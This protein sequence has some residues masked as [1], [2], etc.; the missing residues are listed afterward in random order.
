MQLLLNPEDGDDK[1]ILDTIWQMLEEP[2]AAKL[3]IVL[4]EKLSLLLKHDW[5][6]AKLEA[7]PVWYRFRKVKRVSYDKSKFK[8]VSS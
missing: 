7:K 4:A 6:R 2:E 5:E 1:C 3:H 8:R